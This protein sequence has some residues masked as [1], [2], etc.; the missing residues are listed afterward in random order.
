MPV[1]SSERSKIKD[2]GCLELVFT[3][4]DHG[5]RRFDAVHTHSAR[6]WLIVL[7]RMH[8]LSV[9]FSNIVD[10]YMVLYTAL[11]PVTLPK[12]LRGI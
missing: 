12:H 10:E 2:E 7:G 1:H 8:V 4:F 5:D 9:L 11:A 3:G 6:K